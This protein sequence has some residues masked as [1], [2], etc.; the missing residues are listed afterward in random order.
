MSGHSKWANIKHKKA[1]ADAQKGKVFTKLARE[2]IVAAR[3]GGGDVDSNFRLKI[4][5]QKAKENNMPNDNI[6]RAIQRGTGNLEGQ[7]YEEVIYEGYGPGG[8]AL[9]VE[10][11]TDNR[12]R[13]AA[14]IRHIFSKGGGSLGESGCV[15]WMFQR[16]GYIVVKKENAGDEEELMLQLLD[17]GAEDIKEDDQFFEVITAP[18]DFEHAKQA[19]EEA[20]ITQES[21]EITMLPQTTVPIQ[22]VG[23]A[24]KVIKLVEALED[25]EDVQNVYSN[26]EIP[27]SLLAEIE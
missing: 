8:T 20:G 7:D 4:A 16:K 9:L 11:L 27:D 5:V 10:V 14:D 25:N 15:A 21:A 22:D 2:I 24:R 13:T 6:Q 23:E 12:N 1:R 19:L 26:F 18:E 17:A 3:Q